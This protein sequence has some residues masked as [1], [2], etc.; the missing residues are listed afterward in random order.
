MSNLHRLAWPVLAW[1]LVGVP[2]EGAAAP[3]QAAA[4]C[5]E[6]ILPQK[7]RDLTSPLLFNRCTGATWLLVRRGSAS[8]GAGRRARAAYRWISLDID[9]S[10]PAGG[11][12]RVADAPKP[13][14]EP[15]APAEKC[16]EFTGRRFCE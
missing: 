10:A 8:G 12:D 14:A 16:F 9:D 2:N 7:P 5:F 15:G 13:E 6:I 1:C 4:S 3:K 11:D